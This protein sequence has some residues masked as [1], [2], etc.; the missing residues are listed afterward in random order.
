MAD[1]FQ[2]NR[3][4][5]RRAKVRETEV[6]K[7]PEANAKGAIATVAGARSRGSRCMVTVKTGARR[8]DVKLSN[9]LK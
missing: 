6:E 5:R 1:V 2:S 7:R 9:S 4:R 3:L 8:K